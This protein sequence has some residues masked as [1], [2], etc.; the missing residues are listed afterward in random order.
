MQQK[1]NQRAFCEEDKRRYLLTPEQRGEGFRS[2]NPA[3]KN[4]SIIYR[5]PSV[6]KIPHLQIQPVTDYVVL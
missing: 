3:V 5:R 1:W 4:L 2:V 6:L